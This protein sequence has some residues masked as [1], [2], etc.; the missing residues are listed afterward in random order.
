MVSSSVP[1]DLHSEYLTQGKEK[2]LLKYILCLKR[3]SCLRLR[4]LARNCTRQILRWNHQANELKLHC[5]LKQ[6]KANVNDLE[7]N[8]ICYIFA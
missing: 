1:H 8:A 5:S 4:P 6:V 3:R 7:L 2:L